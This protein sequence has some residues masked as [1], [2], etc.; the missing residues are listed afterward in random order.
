[1]ADFIRDEL[2]RFARKQGKR[3][4]TAVRKKLRSELDGI[5][6]KLQD[7]ID[8][9]QRNQRLIKAQEKVDKAQQAADAAEA[10]HKRLSD[11]AGPKGS[12]DEEGAFQDWQRKLASAKRA[13][14]Q[15]A[16]MKKEK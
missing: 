3:V 8:S 9:S 4:G 5:D 11:E 6:Q 15:L 1:M 14:A 2:G 10:E 16:A 7:K 13:R 12:Y